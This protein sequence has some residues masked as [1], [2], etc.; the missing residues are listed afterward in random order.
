MVRQVGANANKWGRTQPPEQ[1]AAGVALAA[2][3][4]HVAAGPPGG[5]R[6]ALATPARQ[7]LA[8]RSCGGGALSR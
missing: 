5:H 6:V 1:A 2:T 3:S 7:A 4:A 8:Q